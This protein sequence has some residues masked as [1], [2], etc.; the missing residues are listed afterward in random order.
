[1]DH[2]DYSIRKA[3]KTIL[4]DTQDDARVLRILKDLIELNTIKEEE[5]EA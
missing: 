5:G 4:D 2:S 1:M 3:L